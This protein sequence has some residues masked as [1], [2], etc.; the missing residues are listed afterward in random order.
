MH[1]LRPVLQ[2]VLL[3]LFLFLTPSP[4]KANDL[5]ESVL[6]D[7]HRILQKR[8]IL[9][10]VALDDPRAPCRN[11]GIFA[12]GICHCIKGQTGDHCE[13]F[14]CVKGLSVGFRFDPES[15]LFNEP[16]I[17][18]HGWKGEMCDYQPAEKC[19]NKGEWKK[20]RCE[21]VGSYFGSE[22]QYTSKCVEGFLRNGRCICDVGFE[23]DYCDKIICVYGT[24]DFKNRT[25]SCDCPEKFAGRRCEK[26]KKHG[27]LLEPFP[28]CEL[29]P[30]K[31][32]HIEKAAEHRAKV[33]R[34]IRRRIQIIC[35]CV[36]AL[37]VVAFFVCVGRCVHKNAI[38]AK[39]LRNREN[40]AERH[41]LLTN[42]VRLQKFEETV[43]QENIENTEAA[44]A[45]ERHRRKSEPAVLKLNVRQKN[46]KIKL[47]TKGPVTRKDT[48]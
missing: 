21:C 15:L 23:G 7:V 13:H 22:C 29:D 26:C 32:K 3:L 8:S 10:N 36:V 31:K 30:S 16:C 46:D 38:T 43:A 27:P 5:D 39:N 20:D 35:I 4:I 19:G 2:L 40:T 41:R 14:E 34:G 25:L 33:K 47:D 37:S 45:E 18:E 11:G 24:P 44:R 42:H 9:D 6:S 12:G 1:C 28:H 48:R 17:C